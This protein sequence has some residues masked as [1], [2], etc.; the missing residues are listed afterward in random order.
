M[1]REALI[2]HNLGGSHNYWILPYLRKNESIFIDWIAQDDYSVNKLR[3]LGVDGPM[4]WTGG[5]VSRCI[6]TKEVGQ[7]LKAM[8]VDMSTFTETDSNG[9]QLSHAGKGI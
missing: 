4:E 9:K 3:S 6:V 7:K 8:G 5:S 2:K 1:I